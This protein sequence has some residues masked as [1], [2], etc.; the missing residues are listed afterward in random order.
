MNPSPPQSPVSTAP[1]YE[2][3][4][5]RLV[6]A[7]AELERRFTREALISSIGFIRAYLIAGIGLYM[8]F[9]ILDALV[10]AQSVHLLWIIRYAVVSPIL[11]IVLILTCY[12]V[13]IRI[14]Q[15]ALACTMVASG[16][17]IV[18]MTAVMAPPLNAMYYA[19]LIMVVIY[20]SSLIRLQVFI[21]AAISAVLVASYQ[22][23]ALWINPL[24]LKI[25]VSN[26]FFLFMATAV[27]LFS[28]YI[29]ELYM[30]RSYVAQKIIEAKNKTLNV[31][32]VEA[33]KANKSKSEFLANMSHE[34]RT[35]LNAI[36]GFSDILRKQLLGPVG[37]A[38]YAEYVADINDSGQHLL[39]IINDILDLAKA[40]A[41]KLE[42]QIEE[43]D[44][45]MC[46]DDC[47]RMCRGRADN[48]GVHL[49]LSDRLQPIHAMVDRR[50]IFQAVLNLV[51]NAIK[52]TP[53]GG[54]VELRL[55]A[56]SEGIK[57]EVGDTGIGIAPDD[58]ARVLIPFEQVESSFARRQGGTG[59]GLPYAKKLIELHGGA[60]HLAS[61]VGK[62]TTVTIVLPRS[63]LVSQ[64]DRNA[65]K[66]AV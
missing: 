63:R 3:D 48:G 42:L 27:G 53:A 36:I 21:S 29:Q 23:V 64:S 55:S 65:V 54:R 12:P 62:G 44:L 46:L 37:N 33:D 45:T 30:R 40:E 9:G 51:S 39:A 61:E 7:D 43:C 11:V 41:G 10:G 6:F 52:F 35:P 59:L 28:A 1:E 58:M 18:W 56:G 31:L 15:Y 66:I 25:L 20:C 14:G 49:A 38:K 4:K 24:P 32:L 5:V 57:I 22:A 50:L 34:L 47:V 8:V 19:G 13:F 2:L 17:G 60:L 26:D 16:L